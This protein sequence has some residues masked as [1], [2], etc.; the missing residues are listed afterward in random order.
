MLSRS[1]THNSCSHCFPV[2]AKLLLPTFGFWNQEVE[3]PVWCKKQTNPEPC[4]YSNLRSLCMLVAGYYEF[5]RKL[6]IGAAAQTL[7][8]YNF[9]SGRKQSKSN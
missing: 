8:P 3:E 4:N 1:K 7:K 5:S 6:F 9:A 2:K